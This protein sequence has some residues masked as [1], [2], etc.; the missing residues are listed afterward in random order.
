MVS[1]YSTHGHW[2]PLKELK[3]LEVEDRGNAWFED[4]GIDL[5]AMEGIWVALT[6]EDAIQYLFM[7][8]ELE[9][10]EYREALRHPKK[11]LVEVDLKGAI[12]VFGD[13]DGG[14]LYIRKKGGVKNVERAYQRTIGQNTQTL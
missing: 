4:S 7:A 13:G 2:A 5:E 12:P 9:S 1:G 14:T 6:P 3:E 11:Y 10:R 8:S